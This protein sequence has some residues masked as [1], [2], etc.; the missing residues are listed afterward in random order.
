MLVADLWV[1]DVHAGERE[2]F[3]FPVVKPK[4][5]GMDGAKLEKARKYALTGGGSGCIIRG[6][7]LVM[8]W[9]DQKRKYDIYSSTKSISVTA[10]GLA[11]MDGK[12]NLYDKAK[13][14]LPAVGTPP[15]S[16]LES[17][18][19]DEL[20][21]WHLAS[22]TGGFEK[23]RGWCRQ[24]HRPGTSWM[25]SDGG[26][27]WLADCLTVVYGLD[28]LDVM[29]ERVFRPLAI[30]VGD[31]PRGGQHDLHW[32][33][34]NLDRPRQVDSINRRPFGAGIHCNVQAMAKIG[35]LYLRRGKWKGKQI[36]PESFVNL[37]T[38]QADGLD[39]L[40]V[41]DGFVW[42]T[43]A[44]RH[45][46]LLWWNNND[47]TID[48]VPRDAYW[49]WGLKES[50][51]IVVPSLD[52]IAVRAGDYWAPRNDSK[53]SD[54]YNN[55]LKPFLLPICES[56]T[57]RT[58]YPQSAYIPSVTFSDLILDKDATGPAY[59]SGD[60][61]A[62]TW[63]DDG[64]LYMGW[65]DGTGFGHRGNWRDQATAF[66][67]LARLEGTP[68]D[69]HGV[70]L[71]G[72]YRPQSQAGALYVNRDPRP[73]NLKP[74][75]GL[76]SIDG[77][78]YWYAERK[79]DGRVDCQLLTSTDYGR[80]WKDHG[81]FFQEDGKFAFTGIIQFGKD[82]SDAP[83]YLGKY[84]YMFDGG[85]K[86]ESNP[87]FLRKDMLLA[88]IPLNDLL[89]RRAVEFFDGTSGHPSW[90]SD[91]T[92]AKPVF[93]DQRG[94]NSHVSCT[95]DKA[96]GRY[97]LLTMHSST[98]GIKTGFG[99]FESKRPWGPWSTIYYT[100]KLNDF[101]PGLTRLINVSLP[102][103]WISAN[104]ESMWLVFSGRPSDPFYSFNLVRLRLQLASEE[105]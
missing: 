31:E 97:I 100:G 70:N 89:N 52:L 96:I 99:I 41:K 102:S 88:R 17:G 43:G 2:G 53:R 40:P 9:G 63:A 51:I 61:W 47:G 21:L 13:K 75:D 54:S 73:I 58:P 86:A 15:E 85:T 39:K 7:R 65:G 32:G 59:A 36:I 1:P 80:S 101:M 18:W 10:L 26:P 4:Q 49:S 35:E 104:G 44:S 33:F 27:N 28:L 45:Y 66:M 98:G 5:V 78:L 87:H 16:N 25:Y 68:P 74:A 55:I 64:H 29:N 46:G 8:T 91:I 103:K 56:V 12:V 62:G 11:I 105:G 76:I 22:R 81:R 92:Q 84:L 60:Q 57:H 6:G 50:F 93:E 69:H 48:G 34:N 77:T 37:A 67:G 83:S 71:W 90:T 24:A 14:H 72:G 38:S 30:S 20:T 95:Y 23:T 79:S 42:S 3:Q 82:Y 94:V 19:L